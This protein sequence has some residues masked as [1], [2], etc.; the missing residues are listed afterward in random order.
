M[1][2]PPRSRGSVGAQAERS[3]VARQVLLPAQAFIHT[4]ALG[5]AVLLL[6]ALVAV[7]WANSPWDES[8]FD[9]WETIITVDVSLFSIEEDLRHWINDGLMVFFFFVIALEIKRELVHGRFSEPRRAALPIAAAL[10]GMVLPA[11]IYLALNVGGDGERGWGIPMATDTAF[12]LGVLA[13]VGRRV[14]TEVRIFLLAIAIVDDI[15]AILVIAIFYTDTLSLEAL[16]VAALLLGVIVAMNRGGVLSMNLY[17]LVG[18]L[19]WVA[20]LKSGI[21]ATITGVALG[22]LAPAS[23]YFTKQTFAESADRLVGRFRAAMTKGDE[24]T[25]EMVLGQIEELTL[26]VEAPLERL[27]RLI[28]PWT[29]YAVMPLFAL[30]N[31]GIGLSGEVLRDA[32]SSPVTQGVI[33]GLV[34]GKTVGVVS[35]SWLAVRLGISSLPKGVTWAQMIGLGLAAGIGFTVSLFITDLAFAGGDLVSNAKIGILSASI[36]SG[37]AA[38]ACLRTATT[39]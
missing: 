10:G 6:A 25:A 31:A 22:L 17:F 29:S 34:V 26:G 27:E 20:V 11:V 35:F 38:Y 12:A 33:F 18:A 16:G 28:Q 30:A 15:A 13:L 36:L 39:Q 2:V 7:I 37:L 14:P 19:I 1:N 32:V 3:Y 9:L 21:H 24:N 5:G 23:P 8:Y 4:Q